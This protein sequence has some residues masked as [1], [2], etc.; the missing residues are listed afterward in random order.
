MTG[1]DDGRA[2]EWIAAAYDDEDRPDV[3]AILRRAGRLRRR[4]HRMVATS[5]AVVVVGAVSLGVVALG[6]AGEQVVLQPADDASAEPVRLHK[7]QGVARPADGEV[8][9]V[10]TPGGANAFLV[11]D[12][13][14]VHAVQARSPMDYGEEQVVWCPPAQRFVAPA[15]G[16]QWTADGGYAAGPAARG[17]VAYETTVDG[18]EVIVGEALGAPDRPL[19][20]PGAEDAVAAC[21]Q[22]PGYPS[23]EAVAHFHPDRG[24]WPP[25]EEA[26]AAADGGD[27]VTARLTLTAGPRHRRA[28]SRPEGD[29][30]RCPEGSPRVHH[31]STSWLGDATRRWEGYARVLT[32]GDDVLSIVSWVALDT[33]TAPT[34]AEQAR[35]DAGAADRAFLDG[36]RLVIPAD[37]L[38]YGDPPSEPIPAGSYELVLTNHGELTHTLVND[39]LGVDLD[40]NGPAGGTTDSTRI[41][42][43]PGQHTFHCRIPGH[44]DAGMEVTIQVE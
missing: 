28:C 15:W 9:P 8:E 44:R 17:L 3:A 10:I 40:V 11:G 23:T 36:D 1:D 38:H 29:P 19:D 31:S 43:H 16:S 6:P 24:Q 35:T 39:D 12:G 13:E 14:Q 21:L 18:E 37:D 4:R 2:A 26:L 42:L 25:L 41:E 5:A 32:D 34:V 7:G 22:Q 33:F 27:I 30:P 20:P